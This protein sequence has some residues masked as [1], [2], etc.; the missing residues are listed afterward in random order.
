[1][2]MGEK[3]FIAIIKM[4]SIEEE[5]IEHVKSV[6]DRCYRS[7]K[8]EKPDLVEL[9]LFETE[10]HLNVFSR[11]EKER[12]GVRTNLDEAFLTTHDAWT[13]IPRILI[14]LER[15]AETPEGVFEG[16]L[17]HE[18]AH[19]VL[20][21]SI[22]YYMPTIP[23]KFMEASL[24]LGLSPQIVGD[25]VYLASL[26]VKDHEVT[27]L[28]RESGFAEDQVDF[29]IYFLRPSTEERAAWIVAERSPQTTILFM[30]SIL[31]SLACALPLA[32]DEK[33]SPSIQEGMSSALEYL[34][35]EHRDLLWDIL[36]SFEG[37]SGNFSED[38][39]VLLDAILDRIYPL[40]GG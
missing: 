19:S 15:A 12:L 3:P 6:L 17:M 30:V 10:A 36:S 23:P 31:K 25:I 28:L 32:S 33:L 1:M 24:R 29:A 40:M 7:I 11:M 34:P 18:A 35:R 22:E 16:A 9:Y 8:G 5:S 26:A 27:Q 2:E 21:G 37:M 13:G 39:N 20:H 4:G 14:S 38:L